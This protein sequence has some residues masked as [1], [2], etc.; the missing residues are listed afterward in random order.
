MRREK[1]KGLAV[2]TI[3]VAELGIANANGPLKHVGK[4]WFEIA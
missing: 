3:N 2:P 4:H 1:V